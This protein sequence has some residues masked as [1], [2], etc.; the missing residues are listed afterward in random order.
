[1]ADA[2]H[3]DLVA[4]SNEVQQQMEATAKAAGGSSDEEELEGVCRLCTRAM[5]LTK[6]HLIPRG[7]HTAK[8]KKQ[9]PRD[10][11]NATVLICRPCHSAIHR[12]ISLED[13]AAEFNSLD[14]LL[15]LESVQKW[16]KW[17]AKQKVV[18]KDF[19][20]MRLKYSR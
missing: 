7:A 13:M 9:V 1:M 16:V 4:P 3:E 11:L 17:A 8:L 19:A 6:H 15:T 5:P 12:M 18:A 14:A 10:Q 2:I 20:K